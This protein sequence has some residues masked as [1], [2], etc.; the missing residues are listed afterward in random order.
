VSRLFR[1]M[2]SGAVFGLSFMILA[3]KLFEASWVADGVDY[4]QGLMFAGVCFL[5]SLAFAN[6]AKGEDVT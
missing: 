3:D 5:G 4:S 1:N 2:G 6:R